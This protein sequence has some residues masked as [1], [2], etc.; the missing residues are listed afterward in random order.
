MFHTQLE[1]SECCYE[2][3]RSM[4]SMK[5]EKRILLIDINKD[6]SEEATSIQAKI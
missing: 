5:T 6:F 3:N 2:R 1:Y 4:Y